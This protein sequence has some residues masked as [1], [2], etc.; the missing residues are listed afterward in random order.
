ME[1]RPAASVTKWPYVD[2]HDAMQI[3]G[4]LEAALADAVARAEALARQLEEVEAE[5]RG[6]ELALARHRR[7][8][9]DDQASTALSGEPNA[10]SPRGPWSKLTIADAVVRVLVEAD[11]PLSPSQI[12]ERLGDRGRTE[13]NEQ[14]RAGLAYARKRGIAVPVSRARWTPVQGDVFVLDADV[15]RNGD[16]RGTHSDDVHGPS[17]TVHAVQ[18]DNES[19]SE[20][21]R[22]SG[23]DRRPE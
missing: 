16:V 12:V 10:A 20:D 3:A 4:A 11:Q 6:L 7:V 19:R 8:L 22:S 2:Y 18:A 13:N 17:V 5:R 1:L 23:H 14:V 21:H 15:R 9:P